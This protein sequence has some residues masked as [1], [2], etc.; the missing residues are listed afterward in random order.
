MSRFLRRFLLL[1]LCLLFLGSPAMA[2]EAKNVLVLYGNNAELPW[3]KI[4]DASLRAAASAGTKHRIESLT[5]TK[6]IVL[7]F[8]V[9]QE[10][11]EQ[12]KERAAWMRQ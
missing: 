2:Q 5:D 6:N 11:R 4:F 3:I 10:P 1:T 12:R 7:L 9:L 8:G